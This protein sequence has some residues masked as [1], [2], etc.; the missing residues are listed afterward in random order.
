MLTAELFISVDNN[1]AKTMTVMEQ[2][3]V[4]VSGVAFRLV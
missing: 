1:I 2:L 3:L 4:H